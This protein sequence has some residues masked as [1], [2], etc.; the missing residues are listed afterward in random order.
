MMIRRRRARQVVLQ[1]L[2]QYEINP[3]SPYDWRGF[4]ERRLHRDADLVLMAQ[5]LYLGVKQNLASIDRIV[6]QALTRWNLERLGTIDR[7]LI[8]LATYEMLYQQVPH[9]I[10]INEAIEIAKQFGGKNS[11]GFVN[12]ALDRIFRNHADKSLQDQAQQ[13]DRSSGP[14]PETQTAGILETSTPENNETHLL[15]PG[16]VSGGD[17]TIGP[18]AKPKR[19]PDSALARWNRRRRSGAPGTANDNRSDDEL[20]N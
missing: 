2:Y 7:N 6:Q 16:E 12:G 11:P 3:D 13:G 5:S 1:L 10:A 19:Q 4:S 18:T 9:R 17:A 8:R 20:E 14:T 15:N